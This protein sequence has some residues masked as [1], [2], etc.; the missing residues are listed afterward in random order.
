MYTSWLNVDVKGL[1][2]ESHLTTW[3][4]QP[5]AWINKDMFTYKQG[6][7]PFT[8]ALIWQV[9]SSPHSI[10]GYQL[11]LNTWKGKVERLDFWN[12]SSTRRL[13]LNSRHLHNV[14]VQIY[15][16]SGLTAVFLLAAWRFHL[17]ILLRPLITLTLSKMWE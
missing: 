17:L 3:K 8:R 16:T 11:S 2:W 5:L 12:I 10:H 13:L 14:H 15:E 4:L 7:K 1:Y 6:L 9:L